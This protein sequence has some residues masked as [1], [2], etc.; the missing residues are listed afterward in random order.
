MEILKI[1]RVN[2]PK[3]LQSYLSFHSPVGYIRI[4]GDHSGITAINFMDEDAGQSEL[5]PECLLTCQAQLEEYFAGTRKTFDL[6]LR[7]EGTDF[8]MQVWNVLRGIPFG[9]QRSYKDVAFAL[10]N[11]KAIRAVGAANG[12]NRHSIVVPCHRVV[13]NSGDLTGY[14]GGVHR[15]KWLLDHE[16]SVEYGQ[17][18]TL[19]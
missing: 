11:E 1:M 16:Q 18:T 6:P 3:T 14:A 15:K 4:D 5:I 9:V 13:G 8:Q 10:K 19:F 7:A 12:Q 17:Q 2:P